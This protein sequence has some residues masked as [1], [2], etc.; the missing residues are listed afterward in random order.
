[1]KHNFCFRLNEVRLIWTMTLIFTLMF[2]FNVKAYA[3]KYE[4]HQMELQDGFDAKF[5]LKTSEPNIKKIEL[6]CQSFFSNLFILNISNQ[7]EIDF[8]LSIE[9]CEI[10][11]E[12]ISGC[13][14]QNKKACLKLDNVFEQ[15][16]EC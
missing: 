5:E 3:N 1:M 12:N 14:N 6:D 13:L 2:V 4:I 15:K 11:Y 9:E 10:I 8:Y 7:I 16:C